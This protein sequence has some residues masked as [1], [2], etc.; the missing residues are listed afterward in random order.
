MALKQVL[1]IYELLDSPQADGLRVKE[2][3]NSR[4]A[5]VQLHTVSG[6]KGSTDFVRVILPGRSGSVAGGSSPTLGVIGRLGGIGARPQEIGLVSDADGA[7][8]ALAIALKLSDM[9]EQGDQTE[10]DVIVATHICPHAPTIPHDPVPLMTSVVDIATMNDLEVADEMDAILSIDSTRG[11]WVINR[12]GFAITPTVKEGYILKVS[13][14]FLTLMSYVTGQLPV[15]VPVTT[16]DI[17]PYGNGLDHLNSILQ[18]AT[19]TNAPVV[20]IALTSELPVPGMATGASQALDIEM[21]VRF[22]VE[23]AKAFGANRCSF[24]NQGEFDRLLELYGPMNHLQ[25]MGST[26]AERAL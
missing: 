25:T 5:D 22:C 14:S 4:G 16:P 26:E 15:V 10:G 24:Y 3:L 20:G 1:E 9:A 11:N 21:A 2:L 6:E 13:P 17:T 19:A 12:R 7:I 23:I 18:P 8:T